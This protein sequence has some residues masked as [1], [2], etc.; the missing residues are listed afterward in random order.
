MP[1]IDWDI[2]PGWGGISRISRFADG[3][4]AKEWNMLGALFSGTEAERYNLVNRLVEPE[5]LDAEVA[6]LT[7][8]VLSKN[9]IALRR[10]KLAL[11]K[12]AD[13][14]VHQALSLERPITPF[15]SEGEGIRDF[16]TKE[17][18]EKRRALSKGFWSD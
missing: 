5:D 16:H 7:E 10:T 1:E 18:R 12:S 6:R 3:R 4:K 2:T 11:N 14:T 17:G 15:P 13:M 9:P 8:V